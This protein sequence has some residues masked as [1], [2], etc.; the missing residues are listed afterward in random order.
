M[1]FE[2]TFCIVVLL[3]PSAH[4]AGRL[5]QWT[6]TSKTMY[7]LVS[8]GYE[9][10]AYTLNFP[11]SKSG[12]NFFQQWTLLQKAASVYR[13]YEFLWPGQVGQEVRCQV[14]GQPYNQ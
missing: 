9:I 10:K 13:C 2:L 4:A 11:D 14:L 5:T 12:V 1:K 3:A 7:D 6:D 8:D